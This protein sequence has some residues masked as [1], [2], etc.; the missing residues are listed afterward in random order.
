MSLVV[1]TAASLGVI[2]VYVRTMSLWLVDGKLID[3]FVRRPGTAG[4]A[5]VR[6]KTFLGDPEITLQ[7]VRLDLEL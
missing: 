2:Q 6:R 3:D 7:E 5:M 1:T 4:I